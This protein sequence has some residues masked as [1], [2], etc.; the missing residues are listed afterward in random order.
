M[1]AVRFNGFIEYG[2]GIGLRIPHYQH[3][4]EKKPG[5]LEK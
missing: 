5:P 4:L 3:I 2:I 1:P